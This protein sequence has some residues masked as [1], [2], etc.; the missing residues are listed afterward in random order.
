MTE[1]GEGIETGG[2]TMIEGQLREAEETMTGAGGVVGVEA[3]AEA[4]MIKVQGLT[5]SELHLGMRARRRRL[6]LAIWPSLKI[7][8]ATSAIKRRT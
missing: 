5:S 8:M 7:Y 1:T 4:C 6:H 2:M 3:T